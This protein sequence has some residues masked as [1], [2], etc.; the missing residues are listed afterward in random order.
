MQT[1]E[2]AAVALAS[3]ATSSQALAEACLDAIG[4][5]AAAGDAT[6][7]AVDGEAVMAQ[8]EALDRLRRAEA[9]PSPWAGI[10]ISVKDLFDVKG[11]VTRA[12]SRVLADAAPAVRDAPAVARLRQA[13]LLLVGRTNMTEFAYSGLGLNPHYGTPGNP[14][15]GA[16]VPGGSSSGAAVSV[17]GGMALGAIGTDTGGSCRIPAAFCGITG[18]KPT[19]ARV[20]REGVVPLSYSL[21]SVG[22]LAPSVAC[23]AILDSLLAAA[24]LPALTRPLA[25][26]RFGVLSNYVLEDLDQPTASAFAAALS[27]LSAAGAQLAD[28]NLAALE[29]MP[30]INAKGGLSGAESFHWHRA[31]LARDE[32]LY[33]P[34]VAARIRRGAQQSAADYLEVLEQRRAAIAE[35]RSATAGFDALLHP[36]APIVAPRID[37]VSGDE[38]YHRVNLLVLRNPM[39]ANFLDG[40]ALSLPLPV[41]GLPVGLTLLGRGGEDA[42]LF[43]AAAAVEAALAG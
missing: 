13:G 34:R 28:V 8:A 33:D 6:Y 2:E 43:A 40:C 21:D 39:I 38:A 17:A 15:D 5:R 32:A 37:E 24:P 14:K 23:C 31:L 3:G 42:T 36:T 18:Y 9:A 12:G 26:L 29:R 41:A 25:S 1:L 10:P 27:R 7:L 19:Q 30:E 35:M 11:Q 16:R 4:S 22:P 20:P